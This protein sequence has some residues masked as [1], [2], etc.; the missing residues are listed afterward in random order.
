MATLNNSLD[1][2][3][4]HLNFPRSRSSSVARS[5]QWGRILPSGG[6]GVPPELSQGDVLSLVLALAVDTTLHRSCDAVLAYRDL[7]PGGVDLA[8]A[9]APVSLCRTSGDYLMVLAEQAEEGS[10]QEQSD[11]A[12]ARIEV[13]SSWPEIAVH[14][15]GAEPLR[16]V[17]A[18]ALASRW[19]AQGHR[20]ST[21]INGGAFVDVFRE[22]FPEK[23]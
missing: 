12:A 10:K 17:A 9:E 4:R 7:R 6:P 23:N 11:V 15:P 5:L 3:E 8:A 21:T 2:I 18:G 20:R 14:R 13:V 19:Q 1:V 16:F 22:L